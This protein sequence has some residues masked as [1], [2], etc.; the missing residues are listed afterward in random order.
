MLLTR[1]RGVIDSNVGDADLHPVSVAEAAR[2]SLQYADAVLGEQGSS[3]RQ[4]ILE[5][6]LSKC[7]RALQDPTTPERTSREIAASCGFRDWAR[8]KRTFSAA[9]G[10]SPEEFRRRSTSDAQ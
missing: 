8:F 4:L 6:R 9:Y 10:T 7:R 5:H 3:V 2:V 1:I